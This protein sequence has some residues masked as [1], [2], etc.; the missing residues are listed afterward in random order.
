MNH[1]D[2]PDGE[3]QREVQ[4][5]LVSIPQSSESQEGSA[6]VASGVEQNNEHEEGRD[7]AAL[8]DMLGPIVLNTDGS[9]SRISNW[10]EMTDG[11]KASA[12]RLIAKRN[13]SRK[14]ALLTEQTQGCDDKA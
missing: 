7:E 8:L 2:R 14:Q 9:M 3:E 12:Q 6:T 5:Q 11:E 4:N 1:E 13:K 10:K